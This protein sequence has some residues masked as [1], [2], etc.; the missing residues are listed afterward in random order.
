MSGGTEYTRCACGIAY[1]KEEFE[2]LPPAVGGLVYE[3]EYEIQH[4]RNC[5]CGSTMAVVVE[6]KK[7]WEP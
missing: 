5:T 3:D 2:A 4:Y 1:T 6:V 7:T